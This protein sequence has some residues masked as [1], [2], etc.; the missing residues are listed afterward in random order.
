MEKS[1]AVSLFEFLC[2]ILAAGFIAFIFFLFS[3][4]FSALTNKP[5]SI[6]FIIIVTS[7]IFAFTLGAINRDC[8]AD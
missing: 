2:K 7:I 3:M 6:E 4:L 5:S 1:L 8:E